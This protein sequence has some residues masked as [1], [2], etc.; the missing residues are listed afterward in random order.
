MAWD[1][2]GEIRVQELERT[3]VVM[4]KPKHAQTA[5][6]RALSL[7]KATPTHLHL[8]AFAHHT[9][10]DQTEAF[11]T[12]QRNQ[13]KKAIIHERTEW[14]RAEVLDA[15]AAFDD[16]TLEVVWSKDLASWVAERAAG[17]PYDLVVKS[18]HRSRSLLHTPTD[19][20]LLRDCPAP[21]LLV[22]GR[23]WAKR[24]VILAALDL[25]RTDG[26]HER[27]NRRA[28]DAA[29]HF[30]RIYDG[31]V[32]CVYAIEVSRVLGD[33]DIIDARKAAKKTRERVADQARKLVE[34]YGIPA[35]RIHMPAGKVGQVV[36]GIARKVKA[37]LLVMG[38]TARK[39][40]R[41]YVIGNS[42]ERVLAKVPCDV[43]ALKP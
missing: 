1:Y 8:V 4:D 22:S 12:H 6:A 40:V 16:L 30:A 2:L 23:R 15:G 19:W 34:P 14:L 11:D 21:L 42:A 32:H 31:I 26:A 36:N 13:V 33:L 3:L 20:L 41:G 17:A 9:M 24:P 5:F 18:V 10:V 38:T 25:N 43:L 27:L 28:L 35:A 39:G 7:Q 29:D 37:D